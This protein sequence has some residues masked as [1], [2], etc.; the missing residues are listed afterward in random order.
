M[1]FCPLPPG[2]HEV[3]AQAPGGHWRRPQLR[4]SVSTQGSWIP[5][6]DRATQLRGGGQTHG[7]PG[8]GQRGWRAGARNR[9]ALFL[10]WSQTSRKGLGPV[11]GSE[12]QGLG[13]GQVIWALYTNQAFWSLA[14]G[15]SVSHGGG[16]GAVC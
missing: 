15:S 13:G 6:L 10:G 16:D 3:L 2:P 4:S 14:L 5:G 8:C 12:F 7:D 1:H 11:L 9:A